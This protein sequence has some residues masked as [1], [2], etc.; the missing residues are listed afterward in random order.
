M[1]EYKFLNLEEC[2]IVNVAE[3]FGNIS[4]IRVN[5]RVFND[6]TLVGTMAFG[7]TRSDEFLI[8]WIKYLI[9]HKADKKVDIHC[10]EFDLQIKA[11]V[12]S[13]NIKDCACT[14]VAD[15]MKR[16]NVAKLIWQHMGGRELAK[17]VADKDKLIYS[18]GTRNGSKLVEDSIDIG[19]VS[20]VDCKEKF[21]LCI[22]TVDMDWNVNNVPHM[23]LEYGISRSDAKE[24][25][26]SIGW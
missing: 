24:R 4:K 19:T 20:I 26:S 25:S 11:L 6:N 12:A 17:L 3:F 15:K 7:G 22:V 9:W 23:S 5:L 8:Q 21:S 10:R 2:S 1:S 13:Y 16:P 18:Y 14:Y